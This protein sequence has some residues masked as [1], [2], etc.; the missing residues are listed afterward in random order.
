MVVNIKD[1]LSQITI[2]NITIMKTCEPLQELPKCDTNSRWANAVGRMALILALYEVATHLQSV[3][4]VV[5]MKCNKAKCNKTKYYCRYRPIYIYIY[6]YIYII[7]M[8]ITHVIWFHW[9]EMS[10]RGRETRSSL[11]VARN[12]RWGIGKYLGLSVFVLFLEWVR[13]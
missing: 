13:W 2:A 1:Y 10:Q 12:Y 3:K 11:M 6:I 8:K 5:S 4:S 7:Y 9:C